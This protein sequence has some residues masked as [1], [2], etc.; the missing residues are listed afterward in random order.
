MVG[1]ARGGSG[2]LAAC[3]PFKLPL[4]AIADLVCS[5]TGT[6]AFGATVIPGLPSR[7][8][9]PEATSMDSDGGLCP[10]SDGGLCP[11]DAP[12][13]SLVSCT[14]PLVFGTHEDAGDLSTDVTAGD[15]ST[16]MTYSRPRAQSLSVQSSLTSRG[17]SMSLSAQS[18]SRGIRRFRSKSA[19]WCV[20]QASCRSEGS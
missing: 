14:S 13:V 11:D 20:E 6:D 12:E 9:T 17:R 16:D 2:S 19:G 4:A 15:L 8:C 7:A 10:D 5:E 18:P 3:P 1:G